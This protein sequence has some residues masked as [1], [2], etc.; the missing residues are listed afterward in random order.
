MYRQAQETIAAMIKERELLAL[1]LWEIDDA[2]AK[3]TKVIP[4]HGGKQ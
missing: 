2:I 3:L 4:P 1:R